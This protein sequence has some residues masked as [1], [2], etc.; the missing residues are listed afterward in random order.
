MANNVINNNKIERL[1]CIVGQDLYSEMYEFYY[2]ACTTTKFQNKIFLTRR[3]Y[4][5]YRIFSEIFKNNDSKFTP[6]GC[7]FN[8]HSI[9]S[10]KG[11]SNVDDNYQTLIVDDVIING[12][13]INDT[14]KTLPFDFDNKRI[15][16]W[17]IFGNADAKCLDPIEE[18]I[19]HIRYVSQDEWRQISNKLTEFIIYSNI[20]YVSFVNP[21][22]V[23]TEYR[24]EIESFFDGMEDLKKFESK[25]KLF[26]NT[27]IKSTIFFSSFNFSFF[28][29][30]GIISCLRLYEQGDMYTII[31]FVILPTI[32]KKD[33]VKYCKEI[34]SY[35]NIVLP[36]I[37]EN[38]GYEKELYTWTISQLSDQLY[39]YFSKKAFGYEYPCIESFNYISYNMKHLVGYECKTI[40]KNS[41]CL[42]V[43]FD[44][45]NISRKNNIT[46]DEF[47][48]KY[49]FYLSKMFY[50]DEKKADNNENRHNGIRI[51]DI[52]GVFSEHNDPNFKTDCIGILIGSW[53][54]GKSAYMISD[55][56]FEDKSY[57]TGFIKNGEQAY[58]IIYDLYDI[59][60]K[61]F[62]Y[63]FQK[64]LI[65]DK[66][67]LSDIVDKLDQEFKQLKFKEFLGGN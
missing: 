15:K 12:R 33:C 5:L 46:S 9:I 7:F 28:K 30:Y 52:L 55:W 40:D 65:C 29:D 56:E 61:S 53:D 26:N 24:K 49:D 41:E 8:S 11:Q 17:C 1:K 18:Y 42:N 35:F 22:Y 47:L 6:H 50:E 16:V 37:F 32:E 21:Y 20:G 39:I 2:Q 62:Y 23:K 54:V 45:I 38:G 19:D 60:Y 63:L 3:S 59:E 34:L 43:F 67:T 44:S 13:T 58:R 51:E 31:P 57:I 14:I 4:V 10:L 25:E 27:S 64:S 36:R 66:Y 48:K